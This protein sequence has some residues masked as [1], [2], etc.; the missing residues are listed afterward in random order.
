MGCSFPE[1]VCG[2]YRLF[3]HGYH[4]RVRFPRGSFR[5]VLFLST[6]L[7]L[8][9]FAFPPV[10]V[11]GKPLDIATILAAAFLVSSLPA[12]FHWRD[13]PG[14]L[15]ATALAVAAAVVPLLALLP[16]RQGYFSMKGFA[17][18]YGH[19]LLVV[20]FFL[21]ATMLSPSEAWRRRLVGFS[22][23]AA[24]LVAV[25][26]LYQAVGIPRHWPAT[27]PR[28]LPMQKQD[29]G[30][31]ALGAYVRPTSI[32]LEPS[33][34]GGYLA[35]NLVLAAGRWITGRERRDRLI[36]ACA[37][38]LLSVT[39]V[40]TI[41]LGSYADLLVLSVSLMV[42]SWRNGWLSKPVLGRL[43]ASL[44]VVALAIAFSPL[45]RPIGDAMTRRY[46]NVLATPEALRQA[47][48]ELQESAWL[49]VRNAQL[50]V[51][52]LKTRPF[53]GIGLGQ[54]MPYLPI[55]RR[56]ALRL[57]EPWCG[58]LTLAAEVGLL[59]PCLLVAVLVL[60]RRASA[61]S[62]DDMASLC[63]PALLTLAVV[64][65]VHTASF[66]DLWWWYPVSLAVVLALEG[67]ESPRADGSG[68]SFPR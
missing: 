36:W 14:A 58:W 66:I 37:A 8:P 5:T 21:A 40:A 42:V 44:G 68:V 19:W 49:R 22:V 34:L 3:D 20:G 15:R 39:I 47:N 33:F 57:E 43:L 31:M 11:L 6:G 7:A 54:F 38:V 62:E 10:H 12:A 45:G 2:K 32:F 13:A 17:L 65:Q 16:P 25:Y 67:P 9:L 46:R 56:P 52:M 26:G 61:G 1:E 63:V 60:A 23:S 18:S 4:D 29:F 48:P 53:V 51:E 41:S 28:L 30:F 59:G 27:G 24:V 64:Q 35:W 50:A 55:E